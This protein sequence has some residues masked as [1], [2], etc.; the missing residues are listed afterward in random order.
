MKDIIEFDGF[1][2]ERVVL[3]KEVN[4]I[5]SNDKGYFC[6]L[7][8]GEYG[9]ELSKHDRSMGNEPDPNIIAKLVDYIVRIDE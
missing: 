9:F 7:V 2:V 1:T 4:L 8:P 5:V 6:R 3:E